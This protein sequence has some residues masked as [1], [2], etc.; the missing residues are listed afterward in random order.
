MKFV[1]GF[2]LRFLKIIF[3]M[4]YGILPGNPQGYSKDI[5]EIFS[6]VLLGISFRDFSRDSFID[7]PNFKS[8]IQSRTLTEAP[9]NISRGIPFGILSGNPPEIYVWVSSEI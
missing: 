2:L 3:V 5:L 4:S 7:S 8:G 6:G 1:L 9:L